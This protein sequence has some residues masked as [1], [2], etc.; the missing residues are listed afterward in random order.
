MIALTILNVL[1][2]VIEFVVFVGLL[3]VMGITLDKI[4]H[5]KWWKKY[6][7]NKKHIL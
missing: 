7:Q 4:F 1:I 2:K 5:Q 3:Y 6:W